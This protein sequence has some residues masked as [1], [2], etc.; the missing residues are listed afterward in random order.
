MWSSRHAQTSLWC[1]NT[2]D[3]GGLTPNKK[4]IHWLPGH[5]VCDCVLHKWK[6]NLI[7]NS[8]QVAVF[9]DDTGHHFKVLFNCLKNA[10]QACVHACFRHVFISCQQALIPAS[11]KL[12]ETPWLV[13]QL[14][15]LDSILWAIKHVDRNIHEM[16]LVRN[17]DSMASPD[18]NLYWFER[19]QCCSCRHLCAAPVISFGN[20]CHPMQDMLLDFLRSLIM[21]GGK[22]LDVFYQQ[23]F[24]RILKDQLAVRCAHRWVSVHV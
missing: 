1:H 20:M 6:L 2:N 12:T 24:N 22:G 18:F 23:C 11:T 19:L 3:H 21:K 16:G 4:Q 5:T 7:S 14:H 9:H 17:L 15:I 10:T 8:L 13:V